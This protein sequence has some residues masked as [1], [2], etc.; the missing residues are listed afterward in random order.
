MRR[1]DETTLA[2]YVAGT[3]RRLAVHAQP[4]QLICPD[5]SIARFPVKPA[6]RKFS[7]FRKSG[8]AELSMHPHSLG[9]AGCGGREGAGRRTARDADG[10]VVWS[11]RAHAG[12]KF[13]RGSRGRARTTVANAGSP[14]RVR[15]TP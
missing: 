6:S 9:E 15:S 8:L 3:I 10:Q 5:G 2:R 1:L 14:G 11:W 13:S 4:S 7:S 12:A